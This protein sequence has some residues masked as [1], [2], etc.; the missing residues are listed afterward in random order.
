M[1]SSMALRQRDYKPVQAT[2][3]NR[4]AAAP[5]GCQSGGITARRGVLLTRCSRTATGLATIA[6]DAQGEREGFMATTIAKAP[7]PYVPGA[8]G[9]D[10]WA[11]TMAAIENAQYLGLTTYR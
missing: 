4:R 6:G 11:A 10:T 1:M 7:A 5:R 2:D 8:I 9:Q 3:R